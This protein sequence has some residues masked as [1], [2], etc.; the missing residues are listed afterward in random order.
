MP[1]CSPVLV[2][3]RTYAE[4]MSNPSENGFLG[5]VRRV[6]VRDLNI[7]DDISLPI[8]SDG[9]RSVGLRSTVKGFN[10]ARSEMTLHI[11]RTDETVTAE[12][13]PNDLFDRVA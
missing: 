5:P 3:T 1:M 11:H 10:P 7:N 6:A 9:M 12:V 13:D 8:E 2:G 4:H